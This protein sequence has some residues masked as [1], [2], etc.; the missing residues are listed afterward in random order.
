MG[1]LGSYYSGDTYQYAKI[2]KNRLEAQGFDVS[3]R[4]YGREVW[5]QHRQK[6]LNFGVIIIEKRGDEMLTKEM[7]Y[8]MGPY[9]STEP[10]KR[11][12]RRWAAAIVEGIQLEDAAKALTSYKYYPEVLELLGHK[13]EGAECV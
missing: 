9:T 3:V 11:M 12:V 10:P 7:T 8:D 13:L 5:I 4:A 1:W 2:K 6:L